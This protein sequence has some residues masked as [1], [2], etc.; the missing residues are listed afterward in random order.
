MGVALALVAQCGC[1]C[2]AAWDPARDPVL[3]L[4]REGHLVPGLY[5]ASRRLLTL[6]CDEDGFLDIRLEPRDRDYIEV[7]KQ[8]RVIREISAIED[9]EQIRYLVKHPKGFGMMSE[10]QLLGAD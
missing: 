1:R 7:G 2:V 9:D 3:T 5:V 4:S 10:R 8:F 6:A